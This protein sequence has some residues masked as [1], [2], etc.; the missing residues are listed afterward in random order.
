MATNQA[1]THNRSLELRDLANALELACVDFKWFEV[2]QILAK[3]MDR[4]IDIGELLGPLG[5][6]VGCRDFALHI[7]SDLD[8]RI[9]KMRLVG[10][11]PEPDPEDLVAEDLVAHEPLQSKYAPRQTQPPEPIEEP[12]QEQ[13]THDESPLTTGPENPAVESDRSTG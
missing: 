7:I 5:E 4:M 13:P 6:E 2:S 8:S 1:I 10:T 9:T 12:E 11:T 3:M